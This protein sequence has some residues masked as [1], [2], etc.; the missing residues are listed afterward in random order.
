MIKS[1]WQKIFICKCENVLPFPS[2]K[3]CLLFEGA[4]NCYKKPGSKL[5]VSKL[6]LTEFS[7]LNSK[8]FSHLKTAKSF[9]ICK[10]MSFGIST[11]VIIEEMASEKSQT[12]AETEVA[13][14]ALTSKA[15]FSC[16][17]TLRWS[18]NWILAWPFCALQLPHTHTGWDKKN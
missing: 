2:V 6:V 17:S 5:Q 14:L 7:T 12:T 15:R 11:F 1:K 4:K 13:I 3:K 16:N 8:F 10:W 9:H 18:R